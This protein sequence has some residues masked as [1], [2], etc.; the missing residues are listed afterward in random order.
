MPSLSLKSLKRSI[1]DI[2]KFIALLVILPK[3]YSQSLYLPDGILADAKCGLSVSIVNTRGYGQEGFVEVIEDGKAVDVYK[4]KKGLVEICDPPWQLFSIRIVLA[5]GTRLTLENLDYSK[6]RTQEF[7]VSV[8]ESFQHS[9]I[10]AS[11]FKQQLCSI[12]FKVVS[13]LNAAEK[14][15][16][17]S[18]AWIRMNGGQKSVDQYGRVQL[19][20]PYG[21]S[22]DVTFGAEGFESKTVKVP[23]N[24]SSDLEKNQ[25]VLLERR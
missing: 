18:T 19:M 6:S 12:L 1:V 4:I 25:M 11:G 14:T 7:K 3:G 15:N 10:R 5:N 24:V 9:V 20:L 8:P 21:T 17:L 23:C 13:S 2:C 22:E 16:V